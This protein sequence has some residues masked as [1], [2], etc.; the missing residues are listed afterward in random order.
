MN[1]PKTIVVS[2][3]ISALDQRLYKGKE[4]E[5]MIDS[6]LRNLKDT[7]YNSLEVNNAIHKSTT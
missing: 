7:I 1:E 2:L 6:R 5:D 4:L 3:A